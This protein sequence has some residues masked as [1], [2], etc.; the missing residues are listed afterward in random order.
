[1]LICDDIRRRDQPPNAV[2]HI[3]GSLVVMIMRGNHAVILFDHIVD[4]LNLFGRVNH[5]VTE[6]V[7]QRAV[8]AVVYVAA[9]FMSVLDTTIVTVALPAIAHDFEVSVAQVG[10]VQVAYLVAL[11]VFIPVSGWIGDRIGGKRALL[12]AI[13][14]FTL[15]SA[16]CGIATSLPELVVFS[17]IQGVGGAVMLPVGLAMLF[18]VYPPS[19]RVQLSATLALVTAIGPALGPVLGGLFTTYGSWRWVFFV[20]VPIG[21]LALF[22]GLVRLKPHTQPSPGRLDMAGF[23]LAATGFGALMTGV[24]EGSSVGWDHPL[25]LALIVA[26]AILLVLLVIVERRVDR[27]LIELRLFRNH[28]FTSATCLY[29]LASVAYI[30]GLYVVSTFLQEALGASALEAGTTSVASAVGVII[31]GQLVSRVLYHRLGPR[32][33]TTTGLILI[34]AGLAL[35]A[36]AGT[37]TSLWWMRGDLLLLG[38]GVGAVFIPSQAISMATISSTDTGKASPIFNAGKQLGSA[39]GVALLA[40]VLTL[41]TAPNVNSGNDGG[42][43]FPFHLAF[44]VAAAVAL[45][46]TPVALRIRDSEASATMTRSKD[47]AEAG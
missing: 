18:R 31:G 30:G 27:P 28:L 41:T 23:L 10:A 12:G 39:V 8:V 32:R 19:E 6:N 17:A 35:M 40:S 13:G 36:I 26:G 44:L 45:A 24:S 21:L 47:T 11:T 33:L 43:L 42:A 5:M 15:G 46:S 9:M 29:G 38:L 4:L 20:N 37:G 7:S 3:P 25:V 22:W 16:L 14:L 34:G 1:M 2:P